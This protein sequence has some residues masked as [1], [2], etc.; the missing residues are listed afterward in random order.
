[1]KIIIDSKVPDLK[2]VGGSMG[3]FLGGYLVWWFDPHLQG[4][5]L[6]TFEPFQLG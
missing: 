6:F 5:E 3:S 2:T 4:H 1:M